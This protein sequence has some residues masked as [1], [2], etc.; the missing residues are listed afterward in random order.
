MC[1][2]FIE[3]K[4]VPKASFERKQSKSVQILIR[5]STLPRKMEYCTGRLMIQ[6]LGELIQ[7]LLPKCWKELVIQSIH[8]ELGH[9]SIVR[10]FDSIRVRCFWPKMF[11]EIRRNCKKSNCCGVSKILSPKVDTIMG[12]CTASKP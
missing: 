10:T 3:T 7:I 9:Q 8:D 1:K 12:H 5:Q 11:S 6:K 4:T 2:V